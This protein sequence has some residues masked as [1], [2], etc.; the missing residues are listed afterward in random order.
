M[1]SAYTQNRGQRCTKALLLCESKLSE[2][3]FSRF[4]ARHKQRLDALPVARTQ[5][6]RLKE[7][8]LEMSRCVALGA[9]H[10]T[11]LAVNAQ[12]DNGLK[13]SHDSL[14]PR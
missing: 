8:L 13:S 4:V 1:P 7:L 2:N 11:H 12:A 3:R 14:T 5:E 6:G 10:Q 9:A